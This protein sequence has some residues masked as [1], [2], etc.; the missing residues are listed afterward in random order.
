MPRKKEDKDHRTKKGKKAQC[1]TPRGAGL[2]AGLANITRRGAWGCVADP[3]VSER[4]C[5][6]N[7]IEM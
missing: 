7:G 2:R 4:A 1:R 6:A 3:K 5:I